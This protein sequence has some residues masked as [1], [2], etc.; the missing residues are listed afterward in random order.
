MAATGCRY[1]LSY[2]H[3]HTET[4]F[5]QN[6]FPEC[7]TETLNGEVEEMK[8]GLM[9]ISVLESQS[10]KC[11]NYHLEPENEKVKKKN[12]ETARGKLHLPKQ[13]KQQKESHSSKSEKE[14]H[15]RGEES[16]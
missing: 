7:E 6:N 1:S 14:M 12:S 3:L 2:H 10:G 16:K 11:A 4:L 5:A 13:C 15:Q 8:C 9:V